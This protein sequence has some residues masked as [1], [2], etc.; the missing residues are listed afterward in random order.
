M[1]EFR[2]R[3]LFPPALLTALLAALPA[4]PRA[5][6]SAEM[7]AMQ[8]QLNEQVMQAP[9][10]VE[11]QARID[12]YVEDA[13]KKDL[14]PDPAPPSYWRPGYTCNSIIGYGWLPYSRCAHYYRYY[15]HYW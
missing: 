6:S 13:M 14:K 9:F 15:G 5:E 10:S 8:R 3:S 2:A 12:A 7:E 1:T 11:D 4:V